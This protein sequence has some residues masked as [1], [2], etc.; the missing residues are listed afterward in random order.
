MA[1]IAKKHSGFRLAVAL[2]KAID[3]VAKKNKVS[4][5]TVV[6]QWLT[7]RAIAEGW[8]S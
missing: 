1:K 8:M 7:E 4:R 3:K 6:E 5:T 2:L